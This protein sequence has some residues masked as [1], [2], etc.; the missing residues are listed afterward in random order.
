VPDGSDKNLFD[1][2]FLAR[3]EYL[4]IVARRT[5]TGAAAGGRQGRRAGPGLEFAEHRAYAPGDDFRHIDWAAYGRLERLLLRLCQEEEDLAIYFL[6][7][8]SASMATGNPAKFDHA[9]RLTAALA[10]VALASL[11]RVRIVAVDGG[12]RAHLEAG[13]GRTHIVGVLDFLRGLAPGGR[14]DLAR[15]VDAFLPH[16]TQTGLVVLISDF[17]DPAGWEKPLL[18]LHGRRFDLW[19]LHVT[20]PAD[21]APPGMADLAVA[22]AE[23]GETIGVHL[24]DDLRSRLAA[25]AARFGEEV[26]TWSL[27]RGIGYAEAPTALPADELVLEVLRRGGL[28]V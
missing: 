5:F 24:T 20:D 22:D 26:R 6:L 4:R 15:A 7:D 21:L 28:V 10:Y 17:L 11:D 8:A 3:L 18:A 14:T 12:V 9:R 27:A 16:A 1:A 23:T 25:E 13:R 2:A 19:C